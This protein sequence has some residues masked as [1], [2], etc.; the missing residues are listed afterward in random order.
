MTRA[1]GR[2]ANQL[3]P[4][5]FYRGFT[6][7]APGSVLTC[8]GDTRVLVT[9]S[10]E[11]RVPYH[12]KNIDN[13]GWLTAEYSLL[14]ASTN[15]R[16][17]RERQRISGRTQ[18]IQRLIGR[19][20]RACV[21]LKN[22]GQRTITIDADVIQADAGT[23]VAAIT[24]GYVA[25]VDALHHIQ[26]KERAN[27]SPNYLWPLPLKFPIAAVSVALINGELVLDP[28]YLEDSAAEVDANI[29]MNSEGGII[30]VQMTSEAEPLP[31]TQLQEMMRLAQFGIDQL[32]SAQKEALAEALV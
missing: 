1:N 12:L 9:A 25:L 19:S 29:V 13:H 31:L 24:G 23:R 28:D 27:H 15:T 18:E 26:E 4:I 7:H 5:Q 21:D 32:V 11:E 14:P 8:F 17:Q 2:L 3:R 22:M 30:E 20:L 6:K 16:N 10:I